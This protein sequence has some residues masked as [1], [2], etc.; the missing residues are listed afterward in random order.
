[1]RYRLRTL[2]IV[3]A[4]GPPVLAQDAQLPILGK[5]RIVA[6]E[7]EGRI[8]DAEPDDEM[9]V[10]SEDHLLCDEDGKPVKCKCSYDIRTKPMRVEWDSPETDGMCARG[11]WRIDGG[12][13]Q[14]CLRIGTREK[15]PDFPREFKSH[16]G[17][18]AVKLLL[19][20]RVADDPP[21]P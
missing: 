12:S 6:Q 2:L 4:L 18:P 14:I 16:K 15:P 1:M 7:A 19:F 20:S 5:W 21:A 10:F 9:V 8:D 11:I 13:L 17:D 3:L